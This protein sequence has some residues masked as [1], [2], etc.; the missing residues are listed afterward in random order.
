MFQRRQ[1]GSI[2]FN[3]GWADYKAGFGNLSGEFWLGNDNLHLLTKGGH[4]TLRIRLENNDHA[5]EVRCHNFI[6]DKEVNKYMIHVGDCSA[7]RPS[8]SC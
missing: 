8:R 5:E 4:H 3:R 2:D 6:I 1:D 7:Q